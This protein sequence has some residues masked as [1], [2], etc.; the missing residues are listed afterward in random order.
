MSNTRLVSDL[1]NYT[2]ISKKV[3]ESDSM[4]SAYMLFD[5][6]KKAEDLAEKEGWIDAD[7]IEKELVVKAY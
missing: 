7:E 3:D 2:D 6:L 4:K 1:E 5:K